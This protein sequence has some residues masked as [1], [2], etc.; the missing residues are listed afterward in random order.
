MKE[1]VYSEVP[2]NELEEDAKE[3]L[4]NTADIEKINLMIKE[5]GFN[6]VFED[7]SAACLNSSVEYNNVVLLNQDLMK[8]DII[9]RAKQEIWSKIY[10][11]EEWLNSN[12]FKGEKLNLEGK[13][14]KGMRFL[15]VDLREANFKRT[16]L[17]D[18]IIYT[19]LR[20][21]D[22]TGAYINN[23]KWLGSNINNIIIEDDKLNVIEKQ[24]NK[25]IDSHISQ[26]KN[27]KTNN[28]EK[29]MR[30]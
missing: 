10:S 22:L 28:Q 6:E 29:T 23:T 14:L 1:K 30:I 17:S 11:H 4:D 5:K 20:G 15:N 19:D 13:V 27:L 3:F 21:A 16:N 26:M 2:I 25:E 18:C 7:L 9:Q 12:G 8:D 24:L